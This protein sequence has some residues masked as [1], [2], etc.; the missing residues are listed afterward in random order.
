MM[1]V[2]YCEEK[3]QILEGNH[4]KYMKVVTYMVI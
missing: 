4:F 1:P 2:F 3:N